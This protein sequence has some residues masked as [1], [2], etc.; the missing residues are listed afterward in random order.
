MAPHEDDECLLVARAQAIQQF[1]VVVH[2]GSLRRLPR[3]GRRL[4]AGNR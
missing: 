2:A 3:R 1:G 4:V